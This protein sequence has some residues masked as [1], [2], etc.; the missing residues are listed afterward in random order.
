[1][2]P[3]VLF[4]FVPVLVAAVAGA[5]EAADDPD[6]VARSCTGTQHRAGIFDHS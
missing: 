4:D 5:V 2:M 1:M 6:H 3:Q